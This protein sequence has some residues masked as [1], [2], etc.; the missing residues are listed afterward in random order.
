MLNYLFTLSKSTLYFDFQ[1][2][3]IQI[4]TSHIYQAE[5]QGNIFIKGSRKLTQTYRM[6]LGIYSGIGCWEVRAEH[7]R[8]LSSGLLELISG[9]FHLTH[10][11]YFSRDQP[12]WWMPINSCCFSILFPSLLVTLSNKINQWCN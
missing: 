6:S 7:Q 1:W 4:N 8:K 9:A 3:M 12:S 2:L 5:I 10:H 11:L